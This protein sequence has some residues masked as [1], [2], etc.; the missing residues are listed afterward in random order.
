[1]HGTHVDD[2]APGALLIHV[3]QGG[4][5]REEGAIQMD[6]QHLLPFREV[7][8]LD[9][10]H[11]LDAG[12]AHEHIDAAERGD[13]LVH[14]GLHLALACHIHCDADRVLA[15]ELRS[16]RVGA[17]LVEVGDGD[18]GAFAAKGARDFLAD[19]AG[20]AGD[21]GNFAYEAHASLLSV[22]RVA[23]VRI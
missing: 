8:I 18:P 15:A 20:G 7:K 12:V 11:G 3:L 22:V 4:S 10:P 16:C 14:A 9:R 19:A 1:M 23:G 13:R 2:A 17:G 21:N 5:R 6:R